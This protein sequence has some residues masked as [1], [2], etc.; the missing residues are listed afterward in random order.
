[1]SK[2]LSLL[3]DIK[4]IRLHLIMTELIYLCRGIPTD[5]V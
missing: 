3:T 1:M 5:K 4:I 2:V